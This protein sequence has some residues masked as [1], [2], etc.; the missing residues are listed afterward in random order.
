MS[1][2][3]NNNGGGRGPSGGRGG[4]GGGERGGGG[5]RTARKAGKRQAQLQKMD[6][7]AS[8]E[9]NFFRREVQRL[10]GRRPQSKIR[11]ITEL[12]GTQGTAGI[13]FSQY[14]AIKVSRS[15][16]DA[17]AVPSLPD[18]RQLASV[19]PPF[20]HLNLTA[21]DRMNYS[22]PTPIQQHTVP[23][24]LAARDVMAAAQTGSGKTVAFLVPLLAAISK[25]PAPQWDG[26]NTPCRP[27]ALIL[28]PTRELAMQIELEAQ[29]LTFESPLICAC[30]YGGAATRGQLTQC[31]AGP[32]ILVATPGRLTDFLDRSLVDLSYTRFLVLDEAD[33]MLDMGF[34]PQL[35]RIVASNLPDAGRRQTLMFSATFA[36]GVQNI[37]SAYLKNDY[38]FVSVGR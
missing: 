34:E 18:F 28:A 9:A 14:S 13:N 10:G 22:S 16:R 38:V 11:T 19:I 4:G 35:R 5:D 15:G 2:F 6:A 8:E 29:K 7:K 25:N 36:D 20:L 26:Q 23:L 31:A 1:G 33:R 27:A 32:D 30:V 24:S 3:N 21:A 37:A 12:F 17:D